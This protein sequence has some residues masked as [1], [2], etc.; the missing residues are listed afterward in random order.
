MG[1]WAATGGY[2]SK[3][4]LN[5][6]QW[7]AFPPDSSDVITPR[8]ETRSSAQQ[9]LWSDE[10]V[11]RAYRWM[12]GCRWGFRRIYNSMWSTVRSVSN[13][14]RLKI[15]AKKM[16]STR[17]Y[18]LMRGFSSGSKMSMFSPNSRTTLYRDNSM[19]TVCSTY[20]KCKNNTSHHRLW[21]STVHFMLWCSNTVKSRNVGGMTVL[22]SCCWTLCGEWLAPSCSYNWML[23]VSASHRICLGLVSAITLISHF[24]FQ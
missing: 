5:L 3:M 6:C 9:R 19:K 2:P 13:Y 17:K 7:R 4:S 15:H 20:L 23:S 24:I 10:T 11:L 21:T 16:P 12:S 18:A 8:E 22:I 14:T 1:G